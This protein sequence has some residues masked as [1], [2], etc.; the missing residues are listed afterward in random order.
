M[1]DITLILT[2]K[3]NVK[4]INTKRIIQNIL[5]YLFKEI[6]LLIVLKCMVRMDQT[7][8]QKVAEKYCYFR[9]I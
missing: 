4:M 1:N 8:F 5:L 9:F 2:R 7:I 3:E 6:K